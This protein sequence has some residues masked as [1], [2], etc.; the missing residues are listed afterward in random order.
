MRIL[1]TTLSLI[2][3]HGLSAYSLPEVGQFTGQKKPSVAIEEQRQ[4]F[5][6]KVTEEVSSEESEN[7]TNSAESLPLVENTSVDPAVQSVSFAEYYENK[8]EQPR[9]NISLEFRALGKVYQMGIDKR[10]SNRLGLGVF[11]GAFLG[12][13][14]GTDKPVFLGPLKHYGLQ[15][16]AYLGEEYG[17]GL[18]A[19][20]GL[21]QNSISEGG[22]RTYI[23]VDGD[24]FMENGDRKNGH[25]IGL[26]YRVSYKKF[27]GSIGMDYFRV[28][29][30]KN[31]IPLSLGLGYF[32]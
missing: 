17:V 23:I 24:V 16:N 6:D 11:Y 18:F 15:M 20:V 5:M 9:R 30:L 32:F 21:H 28:G 14:V 12:E 7:E 27:F 1:F 2:F 25:L 19:K 8:D 10:L 13:V 31:F 4:E 22:H 3:A 29:R 26:G